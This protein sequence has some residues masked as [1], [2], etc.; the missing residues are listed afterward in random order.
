MAREG[1][2][3]VPSSTV[4]EEGRFQCASSW[5]CSPCAP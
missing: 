3:E 4:E 5:A 1:N 2:R